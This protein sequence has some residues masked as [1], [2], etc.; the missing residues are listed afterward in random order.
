MTCPVGA[1]AI[2]AAT[3]PI[4]SGRQAPLADYR[5]ITRDIIKVYPAGL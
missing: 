1:S 3:P 4:L 5:A 2:G